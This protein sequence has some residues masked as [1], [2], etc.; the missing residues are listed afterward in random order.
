MNRY[1]VFIVNN[2][3]SSPFFIRCYGRNKVIIKHDSIMITISDTRGFDCTKS[4]F[5]SLIS[6][7][8]GLDYVKKYTKKCLLFEVSQ[9]E[10]KAFND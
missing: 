9:D 1:F 3:F 6:R 7:N 8:Y 10:F 5:M 4:E 2:G